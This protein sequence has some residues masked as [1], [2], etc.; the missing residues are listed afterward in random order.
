MGVFRQVEDDG[1]FW[2]LGTADGILGEV[3]PEGFRMV[4]SPEPRGRD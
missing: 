4:E 3:Q 2:I 1:A